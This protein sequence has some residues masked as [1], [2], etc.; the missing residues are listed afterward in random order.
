[1]AT[2]DDLGYKSISDVSQDEAIEMLRQIRLS[3]RV[4]L[5]KA[6][7]KSTKKAAKKSAP[8]LSKAQALKLLDMIKED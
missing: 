3:R 5:K 1:L 2:I 8:K 7:K 4:P 6:K